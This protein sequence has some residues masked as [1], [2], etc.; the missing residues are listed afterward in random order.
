[1]A[2]PSLVSRWR[3]TVI[4]VCIHTV[5]ALS[6]YALHEVWPADTRER[7]WYYLWLVD[8]PSSE[9]TR[10]FTSRYGFQLVWH[11]MIVGGVQWAFAG[12]VIDL[13][14]RL[15]LVDATLTAAH[16]V[17]RVRLALITYWAL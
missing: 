3:F 1:M 14:R 11:S 13:A 4:A 17:M 5:L 12:F 15:L 9:V 8:Y 10:V 6:I 2:F 7:V 16:S